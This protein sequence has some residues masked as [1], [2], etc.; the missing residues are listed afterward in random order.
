MVKMKRKH[1]VVFFV[2][3]GCVML[4]VLFSTRSRAENLPTKE[5]TYPASPFLAVEPPP[6][7]A[8]LVPGK[9]RFWK[10]VADY[11][12]AAAE[13]LGL[14]LRVV[15]TGDDPAEF[16]RQLEDV[17]SH[18]L[19]GVIFDPPS[20][21]GED[22]LRI[23]ERNG[24]PCFLM[25]KEIPGIHFYPRTK[26]DQWLG[27][28]TTSNEQAGALLLRT[29]VEAAY[30]R[31]LASLNIL[32]MGGDA[33]DTVLN[34][35]L[36]GFETALMR[37]TSIR[38]FEKVEVGPNPK[39]AASLFWKHFKK[40]P[41]INLIWCATDAMALAVA[42]RAARMAPGAQL[43][44]GGIGWDRGALQAVDKGI[45]QASVGGNVF[46]GAWAV[47]MLYDYL[48]GVDFASEGVS[49]ETPL[50]GADANNAKKLTYL[51]GISPDSIDFGRFSKT[52]NPDRQSYNFNLLE[53]ASPPQSPAES[54]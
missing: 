4:C 13:D 11:A 29:L 39:Q 8:L 46:E 50:F 34:D 30:E 49:F 9:N 1:S 6:Q 18:G 47:I 44:I 15:D 36:K 14:R 20:D 32:A 7:V 2:L 24:V 19:D 37:Q 5:R 31:G 51:Q 35:R 28:M 33:S 27:G 41:E 16:L 42:E 12:Q 23:A 54:Q 26:Y 48:Q 43:V 17:C 10:M 22:A 53:L 45:L 38:K 21:R 25:G 40:D 3:L 52:R